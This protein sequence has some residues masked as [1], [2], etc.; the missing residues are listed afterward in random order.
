VLMRWTCLPVL[1]GLIAGLPPD[2]AAQDKPA[3]RSVALAPGTP[4][5]SV[6]ASV[7]NMSGLDDVTA[8][9]KRF[10]DE[11]S[12][13]LRPIEM[14]LRNDAR[15]RSAGTLVGLSAVAVG[16]LHGQ[17]ALTLVGA[18]AIRM[19]FDRQL[20]IVRAR[21]GFSMTPSLSDHGFTVTFS[22]TF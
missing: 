16:A 19:G 6:A 20:G 13:R 8:S 4:V 17:R 21:T 3:N 9:A 15:L 12:A 11:L 5:V 22:R 7:T 2:A 10:S 18:E 1:L 14:R